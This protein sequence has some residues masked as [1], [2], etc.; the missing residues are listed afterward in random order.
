L[1][2][3]VFAA[4]AGAP[5]VAARS[6]ASLTAACSN[7]EAGAGAAQRSFFSTCLLMMCLQLLHQTRDTDKR[8]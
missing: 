2:A 5:A 8:L 3:N 7:L 4:G 6:D 1:T